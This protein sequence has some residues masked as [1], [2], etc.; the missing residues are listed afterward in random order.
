ML[1][2]CSWIIPTLQG[3]ALGAQVNGP[4]VNKGFNE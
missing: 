3:T 2:S 4:K 1:S